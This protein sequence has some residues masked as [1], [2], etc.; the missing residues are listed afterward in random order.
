MSELMVGIVV[1]LLVPR[2]LQ[3]ATNSS[4]S[5]TGTAVRG[6]EGDSL[7]PNSVCWT[8]SS[9][10]P[11]KPVCWRRADCSPCRSC[12]REI[13]PRKKTLILLTL[14]WHPLLF[15]DVLSWK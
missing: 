4:D 1:H 6:Q 9:L 2:A 8:Q 10:W 7:N 14:L 3:A 12:H 15:G 13:T 5:F 11:I